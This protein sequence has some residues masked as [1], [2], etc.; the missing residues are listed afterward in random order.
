[1]QGR[2]CGRICCSDVGPV[3]RMFAADGGGSRCGGLGG[4]EKLCVLGV[5]VN[6]ETTVA[7][8]YSKQTAPAAMGEQ[9]E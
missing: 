6:M 9:G 5:A 3:I 1:M 7:F 4:V 8:N 2:R